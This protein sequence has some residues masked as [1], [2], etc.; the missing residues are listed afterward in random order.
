MKLWLISQ[1]QNTG[2]DSYDSAVVAAETEEQAQKIHPSNYLV[3]H[4]EYDDWAWKMY[5]GTLRKQQYPRYDWAN[6]YKEVKVDYL[7]EAANANF[8]GVVCASFNAG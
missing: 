5:N 4:D 3:F 8:S 2:Y 7:G 6:S 1:T